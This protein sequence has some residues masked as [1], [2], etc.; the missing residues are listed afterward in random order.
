[1]RAGRRDRAAVDRGGAAGVGGQAAGRDGG[2]KRRRAG[3]VERQGVEGGGAA[4]RAAEREVAGVGVESE[5]AGRAVAV[6][7]GGEGEVVVAEVDDDVV[8]EGDG[9]GEGGGTGR[10]V[11]VE[12]DGRAGDDDGG[13]GDAEAGEAAVH[14]VADVPVEADGGASR[15]D[16]ESAV[17][18]DAV[19][20]VDCAAKGEVVARA[21]IG[22]DRNVAPEDDGTRKIDR[23]ATGTGV[24][25]YTGAV[26]VDGGGGD[27]EIGEGLG[28]ADV[29]EG[30]G[31]GAGRDDELAIGS[32]H[33]GVDGRGEGEVIVGA[34]HLVGGDGDIGAEH[35]VTGEDGG[36][37]GCV[38]VVHVHCGVVQVDGGGGDIEVGQGLGIADGA[39]EG[40]RARARLDL[41]GDVL[42]GGVAGVDG[43][44]KVDVAAVGI[45][46]C[47]RAGES[48]RAEG[49]AVESAEGEPVEAHAAGEAGA[50]VAIGEGHVAGEFQARGRAGVEAGVGADRAL[51][52]H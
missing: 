23:R 28:R 13:G 50:G 12:P 30:G 24:N 34:G 16:S 20:G 33:V 5:I 7:G 4:D 39:G 38:V 36:R 15:V 10:V 9:A 44:G 14:I 42:G 48:Q 51:K 17:V 43:A 41:E 11:V 31:T 37:Q 19:V 8:L 1:L 52:V 22:V 27:I 21:T 25:I 32:G 2:G 3:G 35:D 46:D 18:G 49:Q 29:G 26:E 40:D 47:R 45:D 6:D